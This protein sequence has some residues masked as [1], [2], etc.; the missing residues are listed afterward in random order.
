M[1]FELLLQGRFNLVKQRRSG[2][3]FYNALDFSSNIMVSS[4][5][6][7][8]W[9]III[10]SSFHLH[11]QYLSSTIPFYFIHIHHSIKIIIFTQWLLS[12]FLFIFIIRLLIFIITITLKRFLS[13]YHSWTTL[14]FLSFN[15]FINITIFQPKAIYFGIW[16]TSFCTYYPLFLNSPW[17]WS[18]CFVRMCFRNIYKVVR[19]VKIILITIQ[20]LK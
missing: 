1:L 17:L 14:I 3:L 6:Y 10:S 18:R 4:L 8:R 2:R 19:V 15:L 11:R 16:Y 20:L 12:W 5:F 7:L 13:I 9:H